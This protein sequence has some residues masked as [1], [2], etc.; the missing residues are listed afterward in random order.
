[1]DT[2]TLLHYAE[3]KAQIP[4]KPV[5]RYRRLMPGAE[6]P[7]WIEFEEFDPGDPVNDALPTNC[8]E[9]IVNDYL[10][11]GQGRVGGVGAATATLLEGHEL[12]AFGIE[13]LERFFTS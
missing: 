11:G 13:W 5:Y 8:F 7:E 12:V 4:D 1:M 3:H 6:G 9:M 10:A 2:V